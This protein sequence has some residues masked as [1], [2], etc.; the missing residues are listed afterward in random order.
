MFFPVIETVKMSPLCILDM[1]IMPTVA[2]LIANKILYSRVA[3]LQRAGPVALI[4][5]ASSLAATAVC[6]LNEGVLS[7]VL[8]AAASYGLLALRGGALIGLLLL[9]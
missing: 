8:T 4:A 9:S 7:T 3:W 6:L 1:V 2:G 5:V